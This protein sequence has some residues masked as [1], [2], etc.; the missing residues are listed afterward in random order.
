MAEID[1]HRNP[2]QPTGRPGRERDEHLP[3]FNPNR[4]LWDF[5]G[6]SQ[7]GKKGRSGPVKKRNTNQMMMWNLISSVLDFFFVILTCFLIFWAI[8][9]TADTSVR[10]TLIGLWKLSPTGTVVLLF[11][12]M[13]IY[14]VACPALFLYTPGQ[15]ACQI[16]RTPKEISF[17]WILKSTFRLAV[18]FMTGFMILPLFSWASGIDLEENLSGLKLQAG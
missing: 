3:L 10:N 12:F 6:E 5:D 18:L 15:W 13:W 16:T 11:S 9:R 7:T 4:W 8:S 17:K 2:V 14:H 1:K